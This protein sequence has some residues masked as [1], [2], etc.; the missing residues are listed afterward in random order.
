[1]I[2][3]YDSGDVKKKNNNDEYYD[4]DCDYNDDNDSEL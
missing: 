4:Y 2:H 1:M 3:Y